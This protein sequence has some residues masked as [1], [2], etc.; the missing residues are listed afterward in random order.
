M[1]IDD[2]VNPLNMRSVTTLIAGIPDM[3][4]AIY[5]HPLVGIRNGCGTLSL[6]LT[7]LTL[8]KIIRD[9]DQYG[10]RWRNL[11]SLANSWPET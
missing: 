9:S 6:I 5:Y 3:I 11:K 8:A 7:M 2:P 1:R 4:P 10:G